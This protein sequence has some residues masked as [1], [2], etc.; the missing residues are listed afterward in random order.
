VVA[1]ALVPALLLCGLALG[2]SLSPLFASTV[3]GYYILT[4]SYSLRLK[5][6]A[7]LDVLVLS[8]LYTMR[9]FGGT[10]VCGTPT[11]IWLLAFCIFLF[12]SLALI[13]RY[14][15]LLLMRTVEG[16]H[17]HA[18]AYQLQDAELLAALGGASGYVAGLVLVLFHVGRQVPGTIDLAGWIICL[19]YLYWISH[20][21]LTAHRGIMQDDPLTFALRERSSRILLALAAVTFMTTW[22]R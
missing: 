19:I 15:E 12:L 11:S 9:L 5:D 3:A 14:A 6:I 16:A 20:M 17:A 10:L 2:F 4:V 18:R 7:V 8:G 1:L 22:F 21:W 13:K